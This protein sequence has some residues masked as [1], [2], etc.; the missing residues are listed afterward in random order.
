[1]AGD[2]HILSIS[3]SIYLRRIGYADGILLPLLHKAFNVNGRAKTTPY[4]TTK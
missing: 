1:M 2:G 3:N 4:E